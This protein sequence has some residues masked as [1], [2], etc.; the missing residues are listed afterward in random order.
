M[1]Q[2]YKVRLANDDYLSFM[3][4]P[5]DSCTNNCCQMELPFLTY[6]ECQLIHQ[7]TNMPVERFAVL[8][9]NG[10]S[11]FYAMKQNQDNGCV[12]YDESEKKCLIYLI[13]PL[14][15]RLF[16][17]DIY[18]DGKKMIWVIYEGHCGPIENKSTL[19]NMLDSI[20]QG[21]LSKLGPY[22]YGYSKL[23]TTWDQRGKCI[24]LREVNNLLIKND[25]MVS[26]K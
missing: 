8:R 2:E 21:V 20:E 22:L 4:T 13:R 25:G 16:P 11:L 5:C 24:P 14:D 26:G 7:T 1:L 15:C 17:F 19:V 3:P 6:E 10:D 9:E 23:P 12:F 18:H